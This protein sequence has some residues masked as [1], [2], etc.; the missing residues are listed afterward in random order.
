MNASGSI[1]SP[2]EHL[3]QVPRIQAMQIEIL[4]EIIRICKKHSIP[5]QMYAGSL[6]GT[7]RHAGPIPWDDDIDI[8]MLRHNYLRFLDVCETELDCKY[9]LQTR[10][11]D[12]NSP[13]TFAKVRRNNSIFR[14]H[15]VA[16]RKMHHG[17]YVDI[18][19]F[20]AVPQGRLLGKLH[21]AMIVIG[22]KVRSLKYNRTVK[23]GISGALRSLAERVGQ[24][25]PSKVLDSYLNWVF[26]LWN[27][28]NS[29]YVSQLGSGIS[30]GGYW[31]CRVRKQDFYHRSLRS[32]SGLE[33]AVPDNYHVHLTQHFGN[34]MKPPAQNEQFPGHSIVELE[35]PT[36]D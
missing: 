25:V 17:I 24:L 19:P 4:K 36:T 12:P 27:R 1:L 20:D 8:A 32:F 34:Y 31:R 16:H 6:L 15:I 11:T 26:G 3:K 23:N 5:F 21:E 30:S 7:I 35:F 9:F 22:H 29:P 33:V 13:H 2:E 18:F 28:S 14:E 10:K